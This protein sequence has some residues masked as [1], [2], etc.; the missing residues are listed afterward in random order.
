MSDYEKYYEEKIKN[1]KIYNNENELLNNSELLFSCILG[2][3]FNGDLYIDNREKFGYI[4][5]VLLDDYNYKLFRNTLHYLYKYEYIYEDLLREKIKLID[6]YDENYGRY[7]KKYIDNNY[8]Y[9]KYD[10]IKIEKFE[11]K[12]ESSY[13]EINKLLYS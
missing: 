12:Y 6:T 8:Y 5:K 7:I 3:I 10:E 13:D 11:K 9:S 1:K 4:I 2:Y